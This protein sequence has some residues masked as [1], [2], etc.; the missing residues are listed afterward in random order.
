LARV[1]Q[2]ALVRF[3]IVRIVQDS[4]VIDIQIASLLAV[5]VDNEASLRVR[6][7][8]KKLRDHFTGTADRVPSPALGSGDHKKLMIRPA[9]ESGYDLSHG[10]RPHAWVVNGSKQDPLRLGGNGGKAAL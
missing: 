6:R 7:E 9:L 1:L 5:P 3:G 10:G 2:E 4:G 8:C